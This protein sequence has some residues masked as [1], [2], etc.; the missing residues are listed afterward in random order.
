M[1]CIFTRIYTKAA[2]TPATP[3]LWR[4]QQEDYKCEVNLGYM[5]KPC[6]KNSQMGREGRRREGGREGGMKGGREERQLSPQRKETLKQ[7]WLLFF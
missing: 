5:V 2:F 3:A 6:I 4:L 1:S 7:L